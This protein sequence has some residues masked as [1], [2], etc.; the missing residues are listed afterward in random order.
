[1][2]N[3]IPNQKAGQLGQVKEAGSGYN[4]R[5]AELYDL[6]YAEKPYIQEAEFL[7]GCLRRY[8]Q[9]G[10][11]QH[12]LELACGTGTHSF[13]LEKLG[14]GL[15][16]LD[17]SEGMLAVAKRKA[18]AC[19]SAINF[20]LAD[21]RDFE[22]P[23][24]KFDAVLCLFDALGYAVTNESILAVLAAIHK[25]LVQ[26]GILI[27]D[28]WHAPAMVRE[29]D[30]VR[31]KT[32]DLPSGQ[33]IRIANTTL[34]VV[35]QSARVDYQILELMKDGTYTSSSETHL[36]RYFSIQEVSLL[37]SQAGFKALE[38][39][40]GF[41]EQDCITDKTWHVTVVAQST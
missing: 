4:D 40:A 8:A 31:V 9:P 29:Y 13:Q 16:A 18:A 17:I 2:R 32:W 41:N 14:Y 30:P 6:F 37:L 12:L 7:D 1:M 3:H 23:P 19:S 36:N 10:K 25:H 5:H 22:L 35:K 15:T 26:N 11:K 20:H 38:W 39:Y 21:M 33:I 34:D 27:F 24:P 28:F